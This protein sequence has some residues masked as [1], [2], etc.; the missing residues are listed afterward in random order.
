[1]ENKN[2]KYS[3]KFNNLNDAIAHINKTPATFTG[4][5]NRFEQLQ[6]AEYNYNTHLTKLAKIEAQVESGEIECFYIIPTLKNVYY[7]E[8]KNYSSKYEEVETIFIKR[9]F[10]INILSELSTG[11]CHS[12]HNGDFKVYNEVNDEFQFL[13][14]LA[15]SKRD[16]VKKVLKAF[17]K[18]LVA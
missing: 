7:G 2:I 12:L 18:S 3:K 15:K 13:G 9:K 11:G 5:K 8:E 4:Y 17:P 14:Y 1:M 16:E 6:N 10:D